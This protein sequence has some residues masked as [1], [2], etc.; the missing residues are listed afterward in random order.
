MDGEGKQKEVYY[1]Q[2]CR[3]CKNELKQ[4]NEEPCWTCLTYPSNE[5]SHKPVCWEAKNG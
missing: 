5:D 4:E 3:T 2:Y 1:D